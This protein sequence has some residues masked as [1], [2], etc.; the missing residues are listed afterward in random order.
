MPQTT[1]T[2]HTSSIISICYILQKK[3]HKSDTLPQFF[4]QCAL[5][6]KLTQIDAKSNDEAHNS[7]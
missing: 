3:M 5:K 2:K 7:G 1:I 6:H 4:F